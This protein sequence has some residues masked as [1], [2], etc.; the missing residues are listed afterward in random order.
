MQ[1]WKTNEHARSFEVETQLLKC[2][3]LFFSGKEG[4]GQLRLHLKKG[5]TELQ[6]HNRAK[7]KKK[8]PP[9]CVCAK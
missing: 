2:T 9:L 1:K 3:C 4:Q 6:G 8:K 5:R 7:K